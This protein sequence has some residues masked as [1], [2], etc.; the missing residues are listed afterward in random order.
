MENGVSHSPQGLL[1]EELLKKNQ[2][3]LH[4][5]IWHCRFSLYST[6]VFLNKGLKA[7]STR[8]PFFDVISI[9]KTL[10]PSLFVPNASGHWCLLLWSYHSQCDVSPPGEFTMVT[11]SPTVRVIV[12]PTGPEEDLKDTP[13]AFRQAADMWRLKD[14]QVIPNHLG[15]NWWTIEIYPS[16]GYCLKTNKTTPPPFFFYCWDF[17]WYSTQVPTCSL[18]K[19]SYIVLRNFHSS[20][21]NLVEKKKLR[22]FIRHW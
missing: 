18:I 2:L 4:R 20:T 8:H 3:T 13:T 10:L 21:T 16:P 19:D 15:R 5:R 9:F 1:W 11:T 12:S 6:R 7:L 17:W 22:I 14:D